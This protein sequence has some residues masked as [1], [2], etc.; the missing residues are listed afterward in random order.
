MV[1]SFVVSSRREGISQ[2]D[3]ADA[4]G[5][6]LGALRDYEQGRKVN[7]GFNATVQLARALGVDCTAFADCVPPIRKK[8]S[9]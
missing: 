3:L 5:I 8:K 1:V 9:K 6:S 2:V 7:P 4:A